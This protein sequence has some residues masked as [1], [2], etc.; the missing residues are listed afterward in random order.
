MKPDIKMS[1]TKEPRNKPT[2]PGVNYYDTGIRKHNGEKTIPSISGAGK[3]GKTLKT[4]RL[5]HSLLS[6]IKHSTYKNKLK[7][8]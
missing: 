2:H 3:T 5:E 7:M 8:V 1:G 4:R 6:Y